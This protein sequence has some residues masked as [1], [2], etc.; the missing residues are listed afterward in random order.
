MSARRLFVGGN[1]KCNGTM[2]FARN[3]PTSVLKTMSFNPTKVD[4][5]V[6]PTFL[7]LSAAQQALAGSQV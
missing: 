7:H 3:F 6:A 1:W 4:V 5:V 2:D